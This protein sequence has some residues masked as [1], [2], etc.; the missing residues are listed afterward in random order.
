MKVIIIIF[1]FLSFVPNCIGQNTP[2]NNLTSTSA[3]QK[4]IELTILSAEIRTRDTD[5]ALMYSNEAHKIAKKYGLKN[6]ESRAFSSIANCYIIKGKYEVAYQ[7]A[8][9]AINIAKEIGNDSL[10]ANA[11]IILA[12]AYYNKGQYEKGIETCI[13]TINAFEKLINYE[14][15]LSVKIVLSQIYQQRK[16]IDKAEKTLQECMDL[17]TQV[18]TPRLKTSVLHTLANIYGMQE[19]YT[20]AFDIDKKGIA[21]CEKENMAFIKSQF[22]DNM[23]NCFMYSG[24]YAQAKKYFLV[25][26]AI[27]SSFNNKKQMSDTYLNL[28]NL[29]MLQKKFD[30]AKAYLLHSISLSNE[31]GYKQGEHEAYMLLSQANSKLNNS[32]EAFKNIKKAY[33][34]K[35][36]LF[37]DKS[38]NKIAEMEAV[39]LTEKKEQSIKLQSLQLK[40]KNYLIVGLASAIALLILIGGLVLYN[41]N[42]KK[43]SV[44]KEEAHKLERSLNKERMRLSKDLHDHLGTS[45][46]TMIAQA[47]SIENKLVNNKIEEALV[48]V[49]QLSEQS[50]ASMNVLRETIWAVQ[51]TTHTLDEFTLRV[52]IF[53][54]RVMGAHEI[55]WSL[56]CVGNINKN[57]S[58]EQT[59]HLFRMIQEVTQNIIKHAGAKKA[60]Y[61]IDANIN[62]FKISINDD[63]KGF[64][65]NVI[66][67]SNGLKNLAARIKELDGTIEIKSALQKGTSIIVQ[68]SI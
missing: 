9:L 29:N 14:G 21:L 67:S 56:N 59:L 55:N 36:S 31:S 66:Y 18:N 6:G 20:K 4:V 42:F 1:L 51:E 2:I 50:R 37:S 17:F 7:T 35:D 53:L 45:L 62:T 16:E 49:N 27:D 54:E 52:R 46:V 15:I 8:V 13:E 33:S 38:E 28:G 61:S 63:G 68:L 22:Y 39:Y 44:Q 60:N 3:Y 57:L 12:K 43:K 25:S 40:N 10:I 30:V 41:L 48:K 47:D 5:S 64:D 11:N 65:T 26:L 19:K 34:I 24:D 32:D 58:P 23:A